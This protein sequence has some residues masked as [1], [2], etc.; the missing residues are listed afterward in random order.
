MNHKRYSGP[1]PYWEAMLK[2]REWLAKP[3]I[4]PM[5]PAAHEAQEACDFKE[6]QAS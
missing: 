2:G 6:R 4:L 5:T 3:E 1:F